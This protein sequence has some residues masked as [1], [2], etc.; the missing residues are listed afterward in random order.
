M[1]CLV[2]ICH[3]SMKTGGVKTGILR[4]ANCVNHN[5]LGLGDVEDNNGLG[6]LPDISHVES[7]FPTALSER[8]QKQGREAAADSRTA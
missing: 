4:T 3:I 1:S 7:G 2:D 5:L 6:F 8:Q